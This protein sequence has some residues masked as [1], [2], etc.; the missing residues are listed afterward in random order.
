MEK[1]E[2][3]VT[4][5][6]TTLKVVLRKISVK[7]SVRVVGSL[8]VLEKVFSVMVSGIFLFYLFLE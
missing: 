6:T 7:F 2:I 1:R 3:R 5:S 8:S 4:I